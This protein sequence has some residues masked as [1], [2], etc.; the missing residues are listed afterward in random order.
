KLGSGESR[1]RLERSLVA[2]DSDHRVA[3]RAEVAQ[4]PSRAARDV[5][6]APPRAYRSGPAD[7]PGRRRLLTMR[8]RLHI[9]SIIAV[10]RKESHGTL[11]PPSQLSRS[12]RR[13]ARSPPRRSPG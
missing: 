6:H 3:E 4:V 9:A 5:E 11:K 2:V 13:D 12:V 10:R 1:E 7:H 8:T